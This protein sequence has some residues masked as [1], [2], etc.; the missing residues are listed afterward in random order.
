MYDRLETN[1]PQLLMKYSDDA[2][3]END[4]LFPTYDSVLKYLQRYADEVKHLIRFNTQVQSV[5]N[6]KQDGHD[7]WSV[8]SEDLLSNDLHEE[9]YDAVIIASGHFSVP[10]VPD[11][12]GIR[13]WSNAYP[14][15]LVHS[16][17]YERPMDFAGKKV[18][19][20][21]NSASGL[22]ICSQIGKVSQQPIM[23]SARSVSEM[24]NAFT[25]A[26]RLDLPEIVE[27]LPTSTHGRA[28]R[29]IDGRIEE[30]IDKIVFCTGYLYSYPYLSS[31]QPP[32]ITSGKRI[33][34]LYQH[35][36]SIDHPSL[37][38]VGLPQRIIPFRTFEGQ[39]AVISRVWSGRI[40]RPSQAEMRR[41]E[42]VRLAQCENEKNFHVLKHPEDFDYHNEMVVWACTTSS[43]YQGKLPLKW[44]SEEY[45][46]RKHIPDA[47]R[48]FVAKGKARTQA[49]TLADV[50]CLYHDW[51]T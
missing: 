7:Q 22:D 18:I 16:R 15:S 42:K 44:T 49:R 41:W 33:Q 6:L 24:Q 17:E 25:S 43:P 21:G 35:V 45:W 19:V 50:G 30:N 38:F 32:L 40:S 13:E 20:V 46:A 3:L 14:G 10:Y 29:F 5:Q 2:T 26:G 36:F 27:F 47:R 11:I 31:I 8:A 4:Q 34:N 28:V 51:R 39:A 48:A 23:I 12:V 9:L 1:I 37:A